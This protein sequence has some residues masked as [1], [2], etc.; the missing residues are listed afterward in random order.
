VAGA[1]AEVM[2]HNLINGWGANKSCES[3]RNFDVAGAADEHISV[4]KTASA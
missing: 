1:Q 4:I 3:R 2:Q